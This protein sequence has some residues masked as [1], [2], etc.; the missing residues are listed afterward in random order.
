MITAIVDFFF[1]PQAKNYEEYSSFMSDA[2]DEQK[3]KL[4]QRA[5]KAATQEQREVVIEQGKLETL[6][7]VKP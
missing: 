6:K 3:K 7:R 5:A 1:H 4:L 2:S